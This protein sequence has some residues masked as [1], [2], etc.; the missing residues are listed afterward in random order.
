M[1]LLDIDV[2]I[3]RAASPRG[4]H[5]DTA[6]DLRAEMD[7]LGIAQALVYHRAAAEADVLKGNHA[8]LEILAGHDNL[9]PSWVMTPPC[10]GDLPNPKA[11]VRDALHSG[12]RAV[13]MLPAHSLYT[14]SKWS[15]GPLLEALS[16]AK[17]PLLLDYGWH[18][19]SERVIPWNDVKAACEVFPDL[20]VVMMGVTPGDVRDVIA[21]LHRLPNLHLELYRFA[22]PD[23]LRLLA[24]EGLVDRLLFGTGVPQCAGETALGQLLSSA[25]DLENSAKVAAGNAHRL[26]GLEIDTGSVDP[27]RPMAKPSSVVVDAHI[28]FGSWERTITT[29]RTPEA[30]VR[31]MDRCGIDKVVGSSFTGIHGEMRLGNAETAD[32]LRA[33][34]ERLY[35]Y[36][37]INPHFADEVDE[38]LNT[39]F[40]G[41]EGFVGLK[42]HC[43]LHEVTLE[44]SGYEHALACADEHTLPVLVHGGTQTEW[45]TIPSRYPNASFIMVHACAWDGIDPAGRALYA[46]ARDIS[47]LYVDTAGSHAH[48]G[49]LETLVDLCGP[50]KVLYGSDFPMYDFGFELGRVALSRLDAQAKARVCGQN[51]LG[52]FRSGV[53]EGGD[54]TKQS[55]R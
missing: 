48:R 23:A 15:A 14:L 46:L 10:L 2:G 35:G 40:E 50:G 55:A 3:G 37:A 22:V 32:A 26:L 28:H 38:E 24:Q 41:N 51:A 36:C 21:L 6:A 33:Y 27:P 20:A 13:R 4:G 42:L 43:G 47:N 52:F 1:H 9:H 12:V 54:Y 11:W 19:W 39:C 18:A 7:R 17:L 34:P 25:L 16:Q 49:A 8:L 31:E 29:A 5:F 45:E 30:I 53:S 44:H